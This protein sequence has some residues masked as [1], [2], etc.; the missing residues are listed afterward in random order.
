M[1][2]RSSPTTRT[3]KRHIS[4]PQRT[5][6]MKQPARPAFPF[7]VSKGQWAGKTSFSTMRSEDHTSELQS[8]MRSSYAVFCLKKKRNNP[9]YKLPHRYLTNQSIRIHTV[10]VQCEY[11]HK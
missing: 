1:P 10:L 2:P 9:N 8:L 11:P 6:V 3:A 7:T 5:S 4:V